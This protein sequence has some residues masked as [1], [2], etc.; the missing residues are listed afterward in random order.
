MVRVQLQCT[1]LWS[2]TPNPVLET[3]LVL[4]ANHVPEKKDPG[5]TGVDT[6]WRCPVIRK[7][8]P[9]T[10][11]PKSGVDTL[12]WNAHRKY[13]RTRL[14]LLLA[15]KTFSVSSLILSSLQLSDTRIYEP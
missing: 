13:G 7:L 4:K 1:R 9:E 10:L 6:L 12:K 11:I 3:N 5:Y 8:K 2:N 15:N 14:P